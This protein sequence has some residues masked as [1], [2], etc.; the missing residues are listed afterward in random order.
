MLA[1]QSMS[2]CEYSIQGRPYN[3]VDGGKSKI[4]RVDSVS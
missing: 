3:A 1:R 2:S 4:R